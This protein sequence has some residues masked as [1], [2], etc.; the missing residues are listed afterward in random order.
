ME[1]V[2]RIRDHG[3]AV[4]VIEHD[5][6]FIFNLCDRV[7][8]PRPGSEAGRGHAAGGAGRPAGD[9]GVP[10]HNPRRDGAAEASDEPPESGRHRREEAVMLEVED[11][12]VAYG[13]IEA[14]KGITLPRGRGRGRHADRHQRCRQD[15]DAADDVRTAAS[16]RGR[17]PVRGRAHR[18]HAGPQ[19]RRARSRPVA[20]GTA[21]LPADDRAREPRARRLPAQVDSA[22]IEQDLATGVSTCSRC[23]ASGRRK[24]AGTLSG[25]EQQMLAMGRALMSRPRL[26]M[27]DEPSMGLSPHHDAAHHV[28]GQRAPGAGDTILLVE[29]NAQA[30]LSSPTRGYVIETGRIVLAGQR[31]GAARQRPGPQGLPRR[32][33]TSRTRC[34][35]GPG[36]VRR[37]VGRG[38]AAAVTSCPPRS[39][40]QAPRRSE[41]PPHP[42]ATAAAHPDLRSDVTPAPTPGWCSRTGGRSSP[43]EAAGR[44][45][46]LVRA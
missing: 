36:R 16:N 41:R 26:L 18:R 44:A 19:D 37:G 14:V 30:A 35:S 9:R 15:D 34:R 42:D 40:S 10:R 32:G 31:A 38:R 43:V 45:A 25:G 4:V 3:L 27:L 8:V 28:D 6:R 22:G 2:F 21:H 24:P 17:D 33:L 7:A 12:Q 20:R 13:K 5:M 1:L 23:S 11:L 39:A 46:P 29:Q